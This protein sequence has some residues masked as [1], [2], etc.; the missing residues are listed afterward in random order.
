M[1]L[2]HAYLTEDISRFGT[3]LDHERDTST[4]AKAKQ[5]R[6][7]VNA[8]DHLGRT[9]LHL[10]AS[11][12]NIEFVELLLA[13]HSLEIAKA[14]R[15]SGWTALHR[16]LY[17]GKLDVVRLILSKT[18]L[19]SSSLRDLLGVTDLEANTPFD[20]Y[21]AT[22]SGVN[23]PS[24]DPSRGASD[25]Y[26]FGS[27][28]N[29]TLGFSDADDRAYPERV[30]IKRSVVAGEKI[31][32]F[33]PQRIRDVVMSKYHTLVITTD[34]SS[35][36][37]S[38]GFAKNG[39]L[40]IVGGTQFTLQPVQIPGQVTAIAAG[41][42][43]SLVVTANGDLYSWGSQEHRQLGY[44]LEPGSRF[45]GT[46]RKIIKL[47]KET[48]IGVAASAIHSVC[49][50][51]TS[52]YTW[53]QN[54]GQLGYEIVPQEGHFVASP[55]KVTALVAPVKEATA[56]RYATVCLLESHDVLVFTNYGFFKLV[57]QLDR[58][59]SQYQ[60]FRPRQAYA[61]SKITKVVSGTAT[62]AVMTNM[63]DVFSFI[64]DESTA[65][66]KTATL[67]K[68][69]KPGRVWSLRKKHLAIRDVAVGQEG[70]IILC[71]ESGSVFT[72]TKKNGRQRN[73]AA[74][75]DYKFTR[76][77]GVTRIVQVRANEHGAFGLIREDVPLLPIPI[78]T[79]DL[80]DDL[81]CTL[82]Y[83]DRIL[84]EEEEE[85]I[86]I[87]DVSQGSKDDQD[88]SQEHKV[89]KHFTNA[90]EMIRSAAPIELDSEDAEFLIT[91]K[92]SDV[93]VPANRSICCARS[94]ILR[95]LILLGQG[96]SD[97]IRY[98]SVD[99]CHR[100]ELS[101]ISEDVTTSVRALLI[102]LHWIYTDLILTPW[103]GA[104]HQDQKRMQKIRE[105]AQA[106]ASRLGLRGLSKA[107]SHSFVVRPKESL[108][109][110]ISALT[111]DVTLLR[112]ADMRLLLADG[113]MTTH[114]GVLAARSEFFSAML[115]GAWIDARRSD[116]QNSVVDIQIK[117]ISMVVMKIVLRHIFQDE[118]TT[119]FDDLDFDDIDEFL[120]L[121]IE[122]MAAATE[123][124]LPRLK[125]SCQAVLQRYVHRKNVSVILREADIY[126]AESLKEACLDYCAR[127]A[128]L[129]LE[130]ALLNDL[131]PALMHDLELYVARKQIERLPISKAGEL[132]SQLIQRNP[133]V[134]E[135]SIRL[136][137]KY[138]ESLLLPKNIIEHD[139]EVVAIQPK[140]APVRAES[141]TGKPKVP[142]ETS[143]IFDME[144]YDLTELDN[145][146]ST[147]DI[148]KSSLSS[149][150]GR[151][152]VPPKGSNATTTSQIPADDKPPAAVLATPSI[153]SSFPK[154]PIR[155]WK[156]ENRGTTPTSLKSVLESHT[157]TPTKSPRSQASLPG[158]SIRTSQKD[159]KRQQ[160]LESPV[161]STSVGPAPVGTSPW[162]AAPITPVV[163]LK[164]ISAK[165]GP[166]K[167][168]DESR[169]ASS[170]IAVPTS[171][172][173]PSATP[174]ARSGNSFGGSYSKSYNAS[175][176]TPSPAHGNRSLAE[177][178]ALEENEKKKMVEYNAKRS[179]KEIQEQEAFELWFQKESIRLK[180]EEEAS[181]A[182]AARLAKQPTANK[183]NKKKPVQAKG[184]KE[185]T[186]REKKKNSSRA[187]IPPQTP[188]SATRPGTAQQQEQPPQPIPF[189]KNNGK[190]TTL[191]ADV[192][193]FKPRGI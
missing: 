10:A 14:D 90:C 119:V 123:L 125:Q 136:K 164:D 47:S 26:S 55:R 134:L 35:N 152:V 48:V 128:Q 40:G 93:A 156:A 51:S 130:N 97:S 18:T 36:L 106:L 49:F 41:Q 87:D 91:I 150:V 63:G 46:P 157:Q 62:I 188:V 25:L 176:P 170:S 180:Q 158:S 24:H 32:K 31:N 79:T 81:L 89:P 58:F 178:I 102:V 160:A 174:A 129:L 57:L 193:E 39:R 126:D 147:M 5:N 56:T 28:A 121:V 104:I 163:S 107:L 127:N 173:R 64:I 110:D 143:L 131:S 98:T 165:Q 66:T 124:I 148:S 167:S 78:D 118:D 50:T 33:R 20:V 108:A 23:P 135:E 80:A 12:G 168:T 144:D 154:E 103:I 11:D 95:D 34:H 45:E 132:L 146:T 21:N 19:R 72:G 100:V 122:V 112:L 82:P 120:E 116:A 184:S 15:E 53:G 171:V 77:S 114:S 189:T 190:S 179:M 142:E 94:P 145:R 17:A 137:T 71:T 138:L 105:A 88:E 6:L 75:A 44:D 4:R 65:G 181:A 76:T 161:A 29:H 68:S 37:Y 3:L 13:N 67:A 172:R 61:P 192:V 30:N 149:D 117:H 8:V 155:G 111:T 9:V 113:E 7:D 186:A 153:A 109:H 2:H 84:E 175:S 74:K 159:R 69:I 96:S 38:C 42:D 169:S 27:N 85:I 139:N 54:Q 151:P 191:K 166:M 16:A 140:T 115:S 141:G 86:L 177:I 59:A 43:H 83:A 185:S 99:D 183:Q 60:V 187:D 1:S 22:V 182:L 52:L 133:S 101:D 92:Q 162:A 70:N 73:D